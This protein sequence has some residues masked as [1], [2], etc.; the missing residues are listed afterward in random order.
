MDLA[1][2]LTMPL[3]VQTSCGIVDAQ[4]GDILILCDTALGKDLL[5][6][7]PGFLADKGD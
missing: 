5:F 4:E 3:E 1:W 7:V 6:V 2:R